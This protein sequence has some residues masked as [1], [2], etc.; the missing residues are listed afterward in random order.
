MTPMGEV[1]PF[2]RR[3]RG[4]KPPQ[5]AGGGRTARDVLAEQRIRRDHAQAVARSRELVRAGKVVPARIS[6]ALDLAGLHGPDVD[7]KVGTWHG[8]PAGDIDRWEQAI[9]VPT[10]DQVWQLAWLT[11]FRPSW[12]YRPMKPGPLLGGPVWMCFADRR[13]CVA[14]GPDVITEGGVLLYEGKPRDPVDTCPPPPEPLP[15]M[16]L[17]DAPA[18][19]KSPSAGRTATGATPVRVDVAAEQLTLPNRMPDHLRAELKAKLAARKR[20]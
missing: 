3:V 13:G 4:L 11:G 9:A 6:M 20:P 2:R 8:N 5:P 16:P 14:Y 19:R 18:A 10:R 15:G 12:F 17:P 7:L 1:I